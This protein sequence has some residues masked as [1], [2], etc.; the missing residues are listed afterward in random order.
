MGIPESFFWLST[1]PWLLMV[2]VALPFATAAWRSRTYP[3]V[4]MCVVP[5]IPIT[6]SLIVAFWQD[7]IVLLLAIDA[8]LLLFVWFDY[9]LLPSQKSVQAKVSADRTLPS[10]ISINVA[11]EC[12][13]TLFNQSSWTFS[14]R[15]CDDTPEYFAS[16]PAEHSLF[17]PAFAKVTF[18]RKLTSTRRGEFQLERVYLESG[19]ILRMWKRQFVIPLQQTVKVFPDM[20]QLSEYAILARTDRLSLIGVRRTRRVGQDSDF[21]RLRDYTADDNYRHID[22]RT[23][24]RRNKL[25]VRQFQ[26]DQSQRV[27]FLLDCGRMMTNERAGMSLLDHSLNAALMLSYVALAQ[28]DAVGMLC[29]SDTIHT[30]LPPRG[31]RNQL[32]RMLQAGFNQFPRMVESRY[33]RA[34]LHLS[35]HC[36][37]RTLVVFM[38]NLIDEV[39]AGQ[40][41][42]YLGN[43]VG[44]HLPLG[45]LMRDSQIFS[46][47]DNPSDDAP[48]LYRSAVAAEILC[49]RDQVIHDLRHRGSLVLDVFPEDMTAPLVNQYLQVKAKHLL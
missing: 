10:T 48:G 13:L 2:L 20:K 28:G 5:V 26:S 3:T 40:V 19:S 12:E 14:G 44:R 39:N 38:T 46:A 47:A 4:L 24:A 1:A 6:G 7:L 23:T 34:F 30:Y 8:I 11:T 42:D 16:Q 35:N 31:G 37:R 49:W 9:L 33:D 41:V 17:L 36:K 45:V 15:V 18:R 21:E 29:F 43:I 25:T 32:N 22:W 27:M